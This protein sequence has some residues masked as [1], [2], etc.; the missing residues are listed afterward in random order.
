MI[1]MQYIRLFNEK[2]KTA[3]CVQCNQRL[4]TYMIAHI[5]QS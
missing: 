3:L 1:S 5:V 4:C 2:A